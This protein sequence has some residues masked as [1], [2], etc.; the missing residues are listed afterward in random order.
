MEC[1]PSEISV[2]TDVLTAMALVVVGRVILDG[3]EAS[4]SRDFVIHAL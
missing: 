1:L 4:Y 3:L 2:L